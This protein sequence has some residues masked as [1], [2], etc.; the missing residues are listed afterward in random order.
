MKHQL[1][2]PLHPDVLPLANTCGYLRPLLLNQDK[3][4]HLELN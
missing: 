2:I 1:G 4:F 3:A